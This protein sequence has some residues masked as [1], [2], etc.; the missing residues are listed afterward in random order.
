MEKKAKK[1]R[2][3]SKPRGRREEEEKGKGI[4]KRRRAEI[5]DFAK[6]ILVVSVLVCSLFSDFLLR[7]SN[8]RMKR[9]RRR[10]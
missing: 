8:V 7:F 3:D 1:S 2:T 9:G 4:E 5:K 6:L 10:C